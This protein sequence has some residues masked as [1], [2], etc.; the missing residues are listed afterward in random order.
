MAAGSLDAAA[1][2]AS[3]G[4]SILIGPHTTHAETGEQRELY[5]QQLHKHGYSA[6]GREI[7]I[8][9]FLAIAP[10][11]AEA[12]E[13]ARQGA[14]WVLKTYID[15]TRFGAGGDPVQRY[16]DSA[17]IHGTAE[18]VTAELTRLREEIHLDYLI[19]APLSHQTFLSFTD[20]VL[21]KLA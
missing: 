10:T 2:A 13:V 8:T 14:R 7:P 15:P 17:I 12:A 21:P 6:E 20:R 11:D 9:R 16:V 1:W 4:Y 19:G 18:R 5:L 3:A